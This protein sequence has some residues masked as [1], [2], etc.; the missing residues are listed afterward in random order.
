MLSAPLL[1]SPYLAI[2]CSD[3]AGLDNLIR[4]PVTIAPFPVQEQSKILTVR[5]ANQPI[6]LFGESQI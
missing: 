5:L 3:N 6:Y 4:Q 1:S 2:Q